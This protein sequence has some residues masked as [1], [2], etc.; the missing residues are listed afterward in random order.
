MDS[1]LN[2]K[3]SNVFANESLKSTSNSIL[4]RKRRSRKSKNSQMELP[5]I[6]EIKEVKPVESSMVS[7]PSMDIYDL[8][9]RK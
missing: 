6:E 9:Y 3:S 8:S 4:N 2:K 7:P 5:L 1:N